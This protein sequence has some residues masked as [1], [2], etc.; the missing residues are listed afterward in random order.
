MAYLNVDMDYFEHPKTVRLVNLLGHGSD[1][2]P[3]RLWAHCG[4]FHKK[5]G[6]IGRRKVADIE[7]L[8]QW[9][10]ENG[11]AVRA[12]MRVGFL[13][14][15]REGYFAHDWKHHQ[16]HIYA[17][18]QR[19]K[20]AAIHRWKAVKKAPVDNWRTEV[21]HKGIT[22]ISDE[23]QK[24]PE[25]NPGMP[26][27]VPVLSVPS[28]EQQRTGVKDNTNLTALIASVGSKPMSREEALRET[29]LLDLP[30]PFG[31]YAGVPLSDLP[32]E[33][34]EWLPVNDPAKYATLG[35]DL[36]DG[37]ALR[38]KLKRQECAR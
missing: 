20:K 31:R 32:V 30:M 9:W 26:L 33:Y 2:L 13:G 35:D 16:G 38:I 6:V 17:L 36:K 3:L 21:I 24:V 8:L 34:C 5:T 1:V 23:K 4:K 10:G 15:S 18:S 12:L 29:R 25:T 22:Q 37:L 19:N 7:S 11:M 14:K 27:S 28:V